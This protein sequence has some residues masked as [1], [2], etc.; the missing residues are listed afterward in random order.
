[1]RPNR[2]DASRVKPITAPASTE[3]FH[4]CCKG[5]REPVVSI[6]KSDSTPFIPHP[7]SNRLR[8]RGTGE[9]SDPILQTLGQGVG[10]GELPDVT[11]ALS[12]R[13]REGL[14]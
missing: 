11:P 13:S 3:L 5:V 2:W 1:M 9:Q 10:V 6:W 12:A 7:I 8:N 4:T 14:G